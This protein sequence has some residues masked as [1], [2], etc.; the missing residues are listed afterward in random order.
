M[1]WTVEFHK[2]AF[3]ELKAQPL[4]IQTKLSRLLKIATEGGFGKLP[5][6]STKHLAD[7][8]WEFRLKG[9]D[10]I[11]RALYITR[12]GQR[13]VIV[14]IFT[15]KSQKTPPREIRLAQERSGDISDHHQDKK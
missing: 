3:A 10:G 13:L 9:K 6:K 5:P 7:D 12:Q 15:K 1:S 14:R 11:A 2:A 8:L 4:D